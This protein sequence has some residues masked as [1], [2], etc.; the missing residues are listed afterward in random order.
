MTNFFRKARKN[1]NLSQIDI[2]DRLGMTQS[3]VSVFERRPDQIPWCRVQE[4]AA[5]YEKPL[6]YFLNGEV[7]PPNTAEQLFKE[8]RHW[9]LSDVV[10][11]PA[12]PAG[13]FRRFEETFAL[14]LV[15]RPNPRIVHGLPALLLLNDWS[16]TLLHAFSVT[17]GTL[18]RVGWI[19]DLALALLDI[20]ESNPRVSIDSST[21]LRSFIS[22]IDRS[23][24]QND[25][26]GYPP[27]A[28]ARVS[29]AS[30]IQ[31]RW[32]VSFDSDLST[33]RERTE[34]LIAEN[35]R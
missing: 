30:I 27:T 13:A 5:I 28:D 9:G 17:Y 2:A 26:L 23:G 4:L 1:R 29:G 20:H 21:N 8:L 7:A 10:G 16:P 6:Q 34:F 33:F 31:R 11:G 25:D 32:K 24:F 3:S 22:S 15:S 18:Q 12:I 14:A 35:A 19:A